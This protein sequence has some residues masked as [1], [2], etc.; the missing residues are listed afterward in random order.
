M[1]TLYSTARHGTPCRTSRVG[2]RRETRLPALSGLL[3]LALFAASA[4]GGQ[5]EGFTEPYQTIDIAAPESG[6]IERL[7]VSQGSRVRQGDVLATLDDDVLEASLELARARAAATGRTDAARIELKRR[8]ERSDKLQMLARE[9]HATAEEVEQARAN[10]ALGEA[11]LLAVEETQQLNQLEV[12]KSAAEVERRQLRTPIDGVV[13]R[14]H[15][16]PGEFVAANQPQVATVVRL[17]RLRVKFYLTTDQAVSLQEGDVV[18]LSYPE[19][20]HRG[21]GHVE[22]VSP[23]TDADSGTVRVEVVVDNP[24]GTYRSGVRCAIR[25]E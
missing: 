19:S 13:T 21:R 3:V 4:A 16:E 24:Q 12:K 22:F 17:D 2:L 10:V 7:H 20:G 8:S 6:I 5:V 15:R 23:V 25:L 18:E 1:K 14:L 11:E 9:G